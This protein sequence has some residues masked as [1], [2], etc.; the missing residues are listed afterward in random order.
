MIIN[1]NLPK[2]D[3]SFPAPLPRLTTIVVSLMS[4]LVVDVISFAGAVRAET[5]PLSATIESANGEDGLVPTLIPAGTFEEKTWIPPEGYAPPPLEDNPDHPLNVYRLDIGDGISVNVLRFPEFS[6][7]SAIDPEGK[8]L[9]PILGK[10]SLV[11]LT[12]EEVEAKISDELGSRYL[13]ENPEVLAALIAPRPLQLTILGEVIRP[14]FYV[15]GAGTPLNNILIGTGGITQKADLRSIIVRRSLKDGTVIEREVDLFTPLQTGKEQPNIRLQGGDTIIVS[16]LQVGD[17]RDYDRA[18]VARTTLSQA[19]IRVRIFSE[20]AESFSAI[21]V[22]SGSTMLD[23]VGGLGNPA[24]ANLREIGLIRFDA[25]T[26]GTITQVIDGKRL[27]NGDIAQDAV[28]QNEDVIVVGGT[29]LGKVSKA[30]S[31]VTRPFQ[32][33]FSFLAFFNSLDNLF[34]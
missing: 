31:D 19:A 6:F 5:E 3:L 11:G 30:L 21:D 9:T 25:E 22:P 2:H 13:Q 34:D 28:L 12:L 4:W 24:L 7:A 17:D 15:F 26:G 32:S 20:V 23:V 18:F 10:I 16:Q 27:I 1:P 33:V 8:V 14:G 29:L